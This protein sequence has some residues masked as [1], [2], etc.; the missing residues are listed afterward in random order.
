VVTPDY[1]L[2]QWA[3]EILGHA[4][5][6][7]ALLQEALTHTTYAHENPKAVA[8]QRLEFLGDSVV[9]MVIASYIFEQYPGLPEGEL[10]KLRA[11]VVCEPALASRARNLGLGPF[12]RFGRGESVGGRDRESI[13]A[14]AFEAVVAAL[15]LDGGWD[16][17]RSLVLRELVPLVAEAHRGRAL[18]DFKTRLQ[19][20]LQREHAESPVY[21][22]LGEEGPPHN[23][24]FHVAVYHQGN[25]LGDGWGRSKK[26]AEQEAANRALILLQE[27]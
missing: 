16:A 5:A 27:Q 19:E 15:Y 23:R 10:T 1:S 20:Y 4:F 25:A 22:L 26:R 14:D 13:L 9:G 24:H 6:R 7:E 2:S 21:R 17:A 3:R 11:A 18:S 12:L 8:N